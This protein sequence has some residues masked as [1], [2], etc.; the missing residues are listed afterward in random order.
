MVG[1]R[2]EE[3]LVGLRFYS[4]PAVG[5]SDERSRRVSAV[6]HAGYN[7]ASDEMEKIAESET[8]TDEEA[9]GIFAAALLWP[10]VNYLLKIGASKEEVLSVVGEMFDQ[11]EEGDDA[12]N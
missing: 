5:M 7:A 6:A 1:E 2:L 10:G 3:R 11:L 8:L 4:L 12:L 9:T